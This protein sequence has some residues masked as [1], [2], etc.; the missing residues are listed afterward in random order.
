MGEFR[1]YRDLVAWQ[2][3]FAVGLRVSEVT[4]AFPDHECFGLT[5]Q[6][7]PGAVS[8]ASDIAEGHGRP[9]TADYFRFLRIAR[10]FV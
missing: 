8:V 6:L 10:L 7:R 4:K 2:K 5:S 1:D 3:A 9:S